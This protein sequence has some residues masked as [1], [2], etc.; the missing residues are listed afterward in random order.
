MRKTLQYGNISVFTPAQVELM[1]SAVS[2][3]DVHLSWADDSEANMDLAKDTVIILRG[4]LQ[5]MAREK[6][7]AKHFGLD[8]NEVLLLHAAL[9]LFSYGLERIG[10]SKDKRR[11]KEDCWAL[12]K[13]FAPMLPAT[14]G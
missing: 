1:L 3:F 8:G 5:D 11:I 6:N 2:A 14:K 7:Y 9:T 4:K 12:M 10:D 13:H